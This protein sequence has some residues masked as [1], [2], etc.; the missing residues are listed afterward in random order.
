MTK[1]E[2]K[3]K[4]YI[5]Y[6][7]VMELLKGTDAKHT[8][9]LYKLCRAGVI[10]AKKEGADWYLEKSFVEKSI[11]WRSTVI[12]I[13]ELRKQLA[14]EYC[15]EDDPGFKRALRSAIKGFIVSSIYDAFFSGT[16]LEKDNMKMMEKARTCASRR[17]PQ[18]QYIPAEEAAKKVGCSLYIL[19]EIIK[20]GVLVTEYKKTG[21]LVEEKSL[22]AFLS[23]KDDYIGIY[24][25]LRSIFG[26]IRTTF[27]IEDRSN[28]SY[29]YMKL[30]KS[31]HSTFFIT[32]EESCFHGDRRNSFYFP[33]HLR[34]DM[35]LEVKKELEQFGT[36][37]D[38]LKILLEDPVWKYRPNTYR[39]FQKFRKN[40]SMNR[41]TALADLLVNH[42]PKE[43]QECT[44]EDI[45]AFLS[46]AKSKGIS[47]YEEIATKFVNY[48]RDR[49]PVQYSVDLV[50][51][52]VTDGVVNNS[53]LPYTK[54]QYLAMAFMTLNDEGIKQY[55]L[56]RKSIE[57]EKC[58]LI[59]L[60]TI[61]TYCAAWRMS[62]FCSMPIIPL[63]YDIKTM[64]HKILDGTYTEDA[65]RMALKL[66]AECNG[67]YTL[68]HKT[69]DSQNKQYRIVTIP[70]S[71][72]PVYGLVYSI[73]RLHYAG[74]FPNTPFKPYDY[75][76]I[77]GDDYRRIFGESSYSIR[78]ANKSFL[79]VLNEKIQAETP[80]NN[81]V[82]GYM[83][84][85]LA[86]SHSMH[87]SN[88]PEVTNVYLKN[89]M[90]GMTPN[91]ILML[92]W[93][94]GTCSFVPLMLMQ[95]VYGKK[96]SILDVR[97][98]TT[99]LKKYGLD[100]LSTETQ[101]G[102]IQKEYLRSTQAI[103]YLFSGK[104]GVNIEEQT[105]K[106]IFDIATHH[107]PSK[108]TDIQ[109][110]KTAAG[111]ACAFQGR[112]S[113]FGC[114]YAILENAFLYR[115]QKKVQDIVDKIKK[116]TLEADKK[117]LMFLLSDFYLPPVITALEILKNTYHI[118]ID[119]F[120]QELIA[121]LE[122]KGEHT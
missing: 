72:Y 29:L 97:Q 51:I 21:L 117:R 90:D 78:R 112:E 105:K 48:V 1:E 50:R 101:A 95:A 98:Q 11:A 86:R 118:D 66:I 22:E 73:A 16:Y 74:K 53:C 40:K 77:F 33:K 14:K 5:P 115:A 76:R 15:L 84:A 41:L 52:S 38:R 120:R 32:W 83:V 25:F 111:D 57:D 113:C 26:G 87:G 121:I 91:E 107:A 59:W 28:R 96:F 92:L 12:S 100:A 119:P 47:T 56:V 20:D 88:I 75:I 45:A 10:P 67:R 35:Y 110:L 39:I 106:L 49:Y 42:M 114:P 89:R 54:D 63:P 116:T 34:Q 109:C 69:M 108:T 9:Y 60:R 64:E 93:E 85:A 103:Q 3:G 55:D 43:I 104:S 61:W 82:L 4:D 102:Y 70:A 18:D 44:N 65:K 71:A 68:P 23:K 8:I 94:A 36:C 122:D 79:T 99:I 24:D 19:K 27:N 2:L 58:A 31:R 80:S 7:T 13:D 17:A 30:N 46:T 37:E 81:R 6:P 62:D